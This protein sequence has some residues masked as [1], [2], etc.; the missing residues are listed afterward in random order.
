[1]LDVWLEEVVPKHTTKEVRSFRYADDQVICCH[2]RSDSVRVQRALRGRLNKFGLQLNTEKTKV[3]RF[4]KWD[5]PR[6]KQGTFDY[7]GFTFYIRR[8]RKGHSH[9]AIK[10]A[11]VRFY[12]KLR[13]VKQ[14]CKENKE[15]C[16]LR[17]LWTTFASKIRGHIQYYGVSLNSDRVYSFV[18]QATGIFF[19]WINRRSQRKSMTWEQFNAFR[20]AFPLP[21][22][23]T[24]HHLY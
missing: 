12:S 8:S 5:F 18:H 9:V 13:K 3:V 17:P 14:W 1:V 4:N 15:K 7:L 24:R 20:K 21:D 23:N 6:R 19:K 2:Y 22:V 10:T 16:R 11:K